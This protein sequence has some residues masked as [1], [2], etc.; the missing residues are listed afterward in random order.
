MRY[1][2]SNSNK[3]QSSIASFVCDADIYSHSHYHSTFVKFKLRS[4][5]SFQ[6]KEKNWKKNMMHCGTV[7]ATKM[8]KKKQHMDW[9]GQGRE[10]KWEYSDEMVDTISSLFIIIV[11]HCSAIQ[12]NS[13]ERGRSLQIISWRTCEINRKRNDCIN[14]YYPFKKKRIIA[15]SLGMCGGGGLSAA[16]QTI[17]WPNHLSPFQLYNLDTFYLLF[18]Y[19]I[20]FSIK[21]Q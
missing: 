12:L 15:A 8:W 21:Y 6:R 18:Q 3:V 16:T 17:I 10:Q 14:I 4:A 13:L 5:L 19:L 7:N 9:R 20:G 2:N 11:P 1:L